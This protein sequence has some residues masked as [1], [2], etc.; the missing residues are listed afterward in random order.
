MA[1]LMDYRLAG[2]VGLAWGRVRGGRGW[3]NGRGPAAC[4]AVA[5]GDRKLSA[6][7]L[8]TAQDF[9]ARMWFL[10]AMACLVVTL[11]VGLLAEALPRGSWRDGLA[12][13]LLGP[14]LA[15]VISLSQMGLISYRRNQT[16]RYV[17]RGGPQAAAKPSAARRGLP[18]RNDFWVILVIAVVGSVLIFY[19][20]YHPSA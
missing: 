6:G 20:K 1:L 7:D 15:V 12:D 5:R 8:V 11:A 17:L 14:G 3:S 9:A 10:A 18:R 13:A 2:C 16:S 4:A 19:V